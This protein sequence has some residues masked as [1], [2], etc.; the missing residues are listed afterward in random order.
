LSI[1]TA[2]GSQSR[3]RI[4]TTVAFILIVVLVVAAIAGVAIYTAQIISPCDQAYRYAYSIGL[5]FAYSVAGLPTS[6]NQPIKTVTWCF[7]NKTTG[8]LENRYQTDLIPDV[9]IASADGLYAVT[10]SHGWPG[11]PSGSSAQGPVYL[12]NKEG[13]IEWTFSQAQDEVEI[14]GNGSVIIANDPGLYYI[15]GQG[16]V[17]WNYTGY[18]SFSVVLVDN[19]SEVV[20]GVTGVLFPSHSFFGS[21]LVMFDSHGQVLWNIS[22]PD[23][24]F[25]SGGDVAVSGDH[26][27]VGWSSTG[28]NG[29][30][31]YYDLNGTMVWQRHVSSDIL[32]VSF[33]GN[34]STIFMQANYGNSTYDLSGNVLQNQTY[35]SA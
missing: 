33:E 14:N 13:Q 24:S 35:P 25:G 29:T 2:P 4:S 27:A 22:N 11:G 6:L 7:Y 34:G 21:D 18:D 10:T 26:L 23:Q 32:G 5:P 28:T 9:P 15:D 8:E 17:L 19:G 3:P 20:D 31:Y 16:K 30:L 1:N 12:F